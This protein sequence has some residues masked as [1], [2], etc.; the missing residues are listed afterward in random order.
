LADTY[1]V[2]QKIAAS[3]KL[4]RNATSSPVEA[5]V[6]VGVLNPLPVFA[7]DPQYDD[8]AALFVTVKLR[9]LAPL[10]KEFLNQLFTTLRAFELEYELEVPNPVFWIASLRTISE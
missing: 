4:S 9:N 10:L 7:Q 1:C 5:A 8:C 2:L 6:P 3:A